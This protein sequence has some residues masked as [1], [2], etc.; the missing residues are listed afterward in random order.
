MKKKIDFSES[1]KTTEISTFKTSMT[2]ENEKLQE[3]KRSE[4]SFGNSHKK[5]QEKV[6]DTIYYDL[7]NSNFVSKVQDE[8]ED[9]PTEKKQLKMNSNCKDSDENDEECNNMKTESNNEIS[10]NDRRVVESEMKKIEKSKNFSFLSQI[11]GINKEIDSRLK[12]WESKKY[13]SSHFYNG[14]LS[15]FEELNE[16]CNYY[17]L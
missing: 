10:K 16:Y 17:L 14:K 15:C 6:P 8:I 13:K 9:K 2:Q 7:K 4:S 1:N 3:I 5:D 12:K 11:D